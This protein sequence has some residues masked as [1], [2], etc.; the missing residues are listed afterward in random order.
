MVRPIRTA[1][2][3][4]AAR[5]PTASRSPSCVPRI[6]VGLATSST[7][8]TASLNE[9]KV[10]TIKE[11]LEIKQ[12]RIMGMTEESLTEILGAPGSAEGAS[13]KA[14]TPATGDELISD[15]VAE[16][17]AEAAVTDSIDAS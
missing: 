2:G 1:S 12:H 17:A 3:A 13:L 11:V 6:A 4:R 9:G 14:D 5:A 15:A 10:P 16:A 8:R 7:T